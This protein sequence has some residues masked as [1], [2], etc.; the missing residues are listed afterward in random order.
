MS[1]T[2][3]VI[4]IIEK[5]IEKK[6]KVSADSVLTEDLEIDSFGRLMIVNALEDEYGV[7]I[8]DEDISGLETVADIV[9][10]LAK[11]LDTRK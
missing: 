10:K 6:V 2:E 3:N 9:H 7:T 11:Y 4:S 1:L 5:N 8:S